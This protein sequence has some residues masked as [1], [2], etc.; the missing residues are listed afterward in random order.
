MKRFSLDKVQITEPRWAEKFDLNAAFL[1]EM[2]VERVLAGFRRTAGISTDAEPYGGWESGLIAGHG[3]GHY[4]SALA[5][6]IVYLCGQAVA[7]G[8]AMK[9]Q[10]CMEIRKSFEF[11]KSQAER[12][13]SGLRECQEKYGSGFLCAADIPDP[14]NKELQFDIL[15][16]KA[17]GEQWVPWYAMHKVLQ[18]L[19][20]L[21]AVSETK[22]AKEVCLALG[23]WTCNRVLAWDEEARKKVLAVEFGGMNDSLYQLYGLTGDEKYRRAAAAFDQPDLYADLLGFK[24]RLKGVHANTTMPKI[25]GYLRGATVCGSSASGE[26]R[27]AVAERFFDVVDTKQ[28]YMTGG[29]GDMEHFFEDGLLDGSRTQCNGESCCAHNMIKLCQMLF[30]LTGKIKYAEYIERTLWNAKLGSVGPEGGY[31][32]FNPMA[33][34]YYRLY[35]PAHPAENPFWCCVGTAMEDFTKLQDQVYYRDGDTV[36]I[37]Q[38]ISSDIRVSENRSLSLMVDLEEGKLILQHHDKTYSDDTIPDCSDGKVHS[39]CEEETHVKLRVPRWIK[40]R[41]KYLPDDQDYLNLILDAVS[42]IVMTFEVEIDAHILPDS[43]PMPTSDA[44]PASDDPSAKAPFFATSAPRVPAIGFSYG[45]LVLCVPLGNEKWGITEVA[46]IDVVAPAWKV[47]FD[48]SVKTDIHYGRT[49][50]AVLDREFLTLPEGVSA[51]EIKSHPEKYVVR[52]EDGKLVLT[53]LSD[54]KEEAVELPLIPYYQTENERY[55]IYWYLKECS[56]NSREP[57]RG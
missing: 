25:I 47:V 10:E 57:T 6:R 46:G 28:S 24:N 48:A 3:V 15:E 14:D 51:E 56:R 30:E 16:G 20:D 42:R 36:V 4:F 45:P 1:D 13:V 8:E 23:E 33:T 12:I 41:S 7:A 53:G 27:I 26:A 18:G 9:I 17:Q 43:I 44:N 52:K 31:S 37:T 11:S 22:G 49:T 38:W 35:S 40:D 29:V 54:W 55:G 19:I 32:Y 21:W 5:M 34:G 50:K 39:P 2:D